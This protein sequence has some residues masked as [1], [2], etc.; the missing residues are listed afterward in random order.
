MARAG[1]PIE[2]ACSRWLYS[3]ECY[4]S[5]DRPREQPVRPVRGSSCVGTNA[6]DICHFL[7]IDYEAG[8]RGH[9]QQKMRPEYRRDSSTC[10]DRT[11]RIFRPYMEMI[12]KEWRTADTCSTRSVVVIRATHARASIIHRESLARASSALRCKDMSSAWTISISR[13]RHSSRPLHSPPDPTLIL[14]T[15]ALHPGSSARRKPS[16]PHNARDPD[17]GEILSGNP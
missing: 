12:A 8:V 13:L 16:L 17:K 6:R 7:N 10:P 5:S 4:K 11:R 2:L 14:S 15:L 9:R 1:R 3:V